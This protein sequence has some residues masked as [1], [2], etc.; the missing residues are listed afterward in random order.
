MVTAVRR[1]YPAEVAVIRRISLNWEAASAIIAGELLE[2]VDHRG[3]A[4]A[5]C[6]S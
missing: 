4:V 6:G 1:F 5:K 3:P 2:A